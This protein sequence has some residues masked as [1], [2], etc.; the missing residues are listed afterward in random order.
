MPGNGPEAMAA[1]LPT[2]SDG[3]LLNKRYLPNDELYYGGEDGRH[4]HADAHRMEAPAGI[5]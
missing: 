1:M 4:N 5:W 3:I 2:S